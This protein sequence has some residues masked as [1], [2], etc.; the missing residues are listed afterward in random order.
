MSSLNYARRNLLLNVESASELRTPFSSVVATRPVG[1]AGF[2]QAKLMRD[3]KFSRCVDIFC[4][5]LA[6]GLF[7]STIDEC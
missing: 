5:P 2:L 6:L 1:I 3:V 4:I 7:T